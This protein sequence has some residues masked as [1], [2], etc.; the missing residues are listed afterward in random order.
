M[1]LDL[2]GETLIICVRSFF[3]LIYKVLI[4]G[5]VTKLMY[6]LISYFPL[7]TNKR[8]ANK[9]NSNNILPLLYSPK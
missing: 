3:N 5:I 6:K 4:D 2:I 9:T 7:E 1:C 8:R